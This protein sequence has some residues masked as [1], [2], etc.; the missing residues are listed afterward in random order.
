[1]SKK[2]P[3]DKSIGFMVISDQWDVFFFTNGNVL[4]ADEIFP[5]ATGRKV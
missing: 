3:R 5:W 1:M 4:L 2:I